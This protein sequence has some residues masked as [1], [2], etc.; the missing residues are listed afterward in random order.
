MVDPRHVKPNNLVQALQRVSLLLDT[1]GQKPR[2]SSVRDLS[3]G[4]KLPKATTHRLLSSLQYLG[5]VRQDPQSRNYFLGFKLVELGNLLLGQLDIRREAEPFLRDLAD[6]ANET[7][8]LVFLDQHEIVYIDKVEM[9]PPSAGLKMASR[10]GSRNP[11]HSSAVGKVLLAHLPE[12]ELNEY[13]RAKGLPRRTANTIT[14][15]A[16]FRDHLRTVR[17]QGFAVDAEE[18]EKGIR[19]VA[20]P[21]F[22][23][24]GAPVAAVSV[25]VPAFRIPGRAAQELLRKEVMETARQI[26]RRLGYREEACGGGPLAAFGKGGSGEKG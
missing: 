6:R 22:S 4:V 16:R 9:N 14:D 11:A 8:H 19:C 24:R 26:S 20:A 1:L 15:P 7:V 10:I 21:V 17:A 13:L 5:F 23:D 12:A 3:S 2:G 18:N 25:S